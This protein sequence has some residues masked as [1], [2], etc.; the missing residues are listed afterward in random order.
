MF[1]SGSAATEEPFTKVLSR[2]TKKK[3]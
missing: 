2:A 1:V 3:K